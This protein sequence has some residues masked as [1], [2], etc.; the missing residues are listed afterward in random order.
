[1][2]PTVISFD[3]YGTLIDWQS[4]ILAYFR[5]LASAH[6]IAITDEV[7]LA[8]YSEFEPA[9]QS[10]LYRSYREV[11]REVVIRFSERFGFYPSKTE[12]DGLSESL[13]SWQ[14]FGDTVE[15]LRAL[16]QQY[17]LAIVSNID[18]D[19]FQATARSLEVPFDWIIT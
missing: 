19:L 5:G 18:N 6:A 16:K 1:M 15:A 4:G 7:I 11:L 14:P 3:C 9:I 17:K 12:L 2:K 10:G 13:P 8:A